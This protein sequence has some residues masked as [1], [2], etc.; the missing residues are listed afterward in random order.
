MESVL[1]HA[2]IRGSGPHICSR[3]GACL[4]LGTRITC[5]QNITEDLSGS[6]VSPARLQI[7]PSML[8]VIAPQMKPASS[9]AT[10]QI[11]LLW[12]FLKAILL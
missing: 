9:L 6:S 12:C 5:S 10:A 11:A 7:Y 3:A 8:F 2:D 4:P 1:D